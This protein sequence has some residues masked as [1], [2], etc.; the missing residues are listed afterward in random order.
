MEFAR[1]ETAIT[2]LEFA[3]FHFSYVSVPLI[4]GLLIIRLSSLMDKF[5]IRK[6]KTVEGE[7]ASDD[8]QE[9]SSAKC[10]AMQPVKTSSDR[11]VSKSKE[12]VRTYQTSYLK[13]GFCTTEANPTRPLCLICEL[14]LANS[15]MKP[16]ML[17]RHLTKN[18]PDLADKPVEFFA[19]RKAEFE[20]KFKSFPRQNNT[21]QT[22]LELSYD[23]SYLVARAEAPHTAVEK[24]CIP[25]ATLIAEKM[26]KLDK[27]QIL[28]VKKIPCSDN[29]VSRRIDDMAADIREQI[30]EDVLVDQRFA[31]QLDES[32]DVSNDAQLLVYIRYYSSSS[33]ITE[34]IL[35]CLA[36]QTN[37][38]GI[39]VFEALDD[40]IVTKCGFSWDWCVSVCTDGAAAM[41]GRKSGVIAYLKEKNENIE[42]LHCMIHRQALAAKHLSPSLK[43][44]LD[45]AVTAVNLIKARALQ[46]RLFAQL[47]E[48]VGA[49][50]KGLLLHSEV[51]WLSRG[52]VLARVFELRAEINS[53]FL[54]T[55][56]DL[57]KNFVEFEFLCRLAYLADIFY[58]LNELN[59]KLQGYDSNIFGAN[60]KIKA[61]LKKLEHWEEAVGKG[62]F[63]SFPTLDEFLVEKKEPVSGETQNEIREHLNHLQQSFLKYFPN[64]M[65][66][67][68]EHMWIINP[69]SDTAVKGST[70][71]AS[72]KSDLLELNSNSSAK[73]K[74]ND[75]K[76]TNF[77]H[78]MRSEHQTLCD[79]ALKKL[80]PFSTT[81]LCEKGFSALTYIKT[82][83]RSRLHPESDLMLAVTSLQPRIQRLVDQK[84]AQ[85]SH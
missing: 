83:H 81:Y 13:F 56:E 41:T 17:L 36:L 40:L 5:V 38:T 78:E 59:L 82:K 37:A 4:V 22:A 85:I 20:R 51:R 44:A 55:R 62:Q 47:C 61:F 70:L 12:K 23:L 8:A 79:V 74:F 10:R 39:R 49:R 27:K 60:D 14:S 11:P 50:H 77:W 57:A 45:T 76:L 75:T 15:S 32:T 26:H 25:S 66:T 65:K 64:S 58:L 53:F 54:P 16:S 35:A 42:T 68:T 34:S 33:G 7:K 72:L 69:F 63:G 21:S 29:T 6:R 84:Q 28:D 19:R 67:D 80:L 9:H 71:S 3:S 31:L 46:S 18:H 24:L 30:I 52:K 43:D 73:L 1:N 48:E 2:A